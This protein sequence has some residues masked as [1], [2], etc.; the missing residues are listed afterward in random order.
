[1]IKTSDPTAPNWKNYTGSKNKADVLRFLRSDGWEVKKQT[2]YNHCK[3]GK[4]V[5]N[6]NGLFTVRVVKKYAETW[7]VRSVSGLTVAAEEEDLLATKTREEIQRIRIIRQREEF[8]LGVDRGNYI[9][10][11]DLEA[12]LA[13]RAVAFD[14]GLT[15]MIQSSAPDI[16]ALVRGD[17]SRTADLVAFLNEAKDRL[18]NEYATSARF[19]VIFSEQGAA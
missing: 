11:S 6:R 16:V 9:L 3:S 19:A 13:A 4:L 7:L 2:F 10:R 8:K 1:M 18:L 5:K 15:H 14:N 12:E 17:Q